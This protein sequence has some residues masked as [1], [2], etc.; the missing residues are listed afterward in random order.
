M[1]NVRYSWWIWEQIL[2]SLYKA[3]AQPP[4][5]RSVLFRLLRLKKEKFRL[6]QVQRRAL[7]ISEGVESLSYGRVTKKDSLL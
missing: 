3:K 4:L 7:G 5:D 2:M 6:E 1:Y